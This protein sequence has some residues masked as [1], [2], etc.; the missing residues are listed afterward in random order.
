MPREL[1]WTEC[2]YFAGESSSV[3]SQNCCFFDSG[4]EPTGLEVVKVCRIQ[5]FLVRRDQFKALRRHSRNDVL[6]S[7]STSPLSVCQNGAGP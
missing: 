7:F 2:S 4:T 6:L 1:S 3:N 5:Y